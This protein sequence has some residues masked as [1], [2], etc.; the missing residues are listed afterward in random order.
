MLGAAE[1]PTEYWT[2]GTVHTGWP[3]RALSVLADKG[4]TGSLS[5]RVGGLTLMRVAGVAWLMQ[6]LAVPSAFG[7]LPVKL[8][9]EICRA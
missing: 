1:P 7:A 6:D 3:S 8:P 4:L 5:F 2:I 9:K